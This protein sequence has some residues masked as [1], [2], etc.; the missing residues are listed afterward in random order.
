MSLPGQPKRS[1]HRFCAP[2]QRKDPAWRE[3]SLSL[4]SNMGDR[5]AFLQ[6]GLDGL[7]AEPLIEVV[8]VSSVYETD[9]WGL[10]DQP[11]FYNV[12][13]CVRTAL[14]PLALLRACQRIERRAKRKREIHW[15]P[16]TLDIDILTLG[17]LR[18]DSPRLTLPHPRMQE[19]DFVLVPLAEVTS[20]DLLE[21]PGVHRL[22]GFCLKAAAASEPEGSVPGG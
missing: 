6:S 10:T 17:R 4:G 15:G 19:R 3:A 9:P 7:E 14:L 20:G 8:R 2:F 12:V 22:A 21:R 13:V 1:S 18:M 11:A 5:L 16:R